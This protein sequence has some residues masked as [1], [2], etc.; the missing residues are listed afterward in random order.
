M[1][2]EEILNSR[3]IVLV[4]AHPD[5]EV[6]GAGGQFPG[7]QSRLVIVHV[8]DGAPLDGADATARGFESKTDYARAR[9]EEAYRAAALAGVNADQFMQIGAA[10]QRASYDLRGLTLRMAAIFDEVMPDLVV[11]H[12]YEGGH[13]DHD[14]TAYAVQAAAI[15]I[16]RSGRPTPARWE[17]TSYFA[18]EGGMVTGRFASRIETEVVRELSDKRRALKRRMLDCFV[19]Q[20]AMLQNFTV[21]DERFRLAPVYD[22]TE[23]PQTGR[24]HYDGFDWGITSEHF[25]ALAGDA[26]R[27]LGIG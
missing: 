15:L 27:E 7:L 17:F 21:E 23:P 5:D 9:S 10:D 2:P 8:T 20:T 26:N 24:L 25:R 4:A 19:T 16:A 11:T 22:F 3:R 13:P 6:I 14:A 1:G 12:P 18:G